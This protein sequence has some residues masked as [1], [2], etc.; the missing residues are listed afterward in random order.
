[1]KNKFCILIHYHEIALKGNNRKW[2]EKSL[3]KNIKIQ[4]TNLPLT[5]INLFSARLVCYGIEFNKW[6]FIYL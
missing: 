6:S 2:F 4:L 1:M 5:I 3:I